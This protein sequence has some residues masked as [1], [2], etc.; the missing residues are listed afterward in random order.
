[1]SDISQGAGW[2]IASDSRWYPPDLHPSRITGVF[3][4]A[5]AAHGQ[6]WT[7]S[8][9][10]RQNLLILAVSLAL[11][12]AILGGLLGWQFTS[13]SASNAPGTAPTGVVGTSPASPA[14]MAALHSAVDKTAGASGYTASGSLAL[15]LG[16]STFETI[17]ETVIYQAPD[18]IS[19]SA[20]Q[21]GHTLTVT[22]IGNH[23]WIPGGS[24]GAGSC[25]TAGDFTGRGQMTVLNTLGRARIIGTTYSFA[26]TNTSATLAA[27]GISFDPLGGSA[28]GTVSSTVSATIAGG[29]IQSEHIAVLQKSSTNGTL[30]SGG[31]FTFT[32]SHVGSAPPVLQPSGPPTGTIS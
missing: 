21:F 30:V 22:V 31:R 12:A 5:A 32:Y 28:V 8:R 9:P 4:P 11:V 3:D 1:M 17:N 18:R 25:G 7:A 6:I 24:V 23:C 16:R 15:E 19:T 13:N 20:T 10:P 2:W 26:P 27:M 14:Q 29:L